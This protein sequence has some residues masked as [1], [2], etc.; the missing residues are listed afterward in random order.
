MEIIAQKDVKTRKEHNCFGC[1][2]EM[3]KGTIMRT[4]TGVYGGTI[5]K[6]YWCSTCQEY[7]SIHMEY[8]DTIMYGELKSEDAEGWEN[9]RKE[10]EEVT[11]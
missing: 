5:S 1:A 9:V 10:V 4:V 8:G 11:A 6:S 7:W 2:R 3:P